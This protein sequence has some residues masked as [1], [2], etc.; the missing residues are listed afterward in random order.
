MAIFYRLTKSNMKG[1]SEG[2]YYA[3]AVSMGEMHTMDLAQV[4]SKNNSVTVGD[5]LASLAGLIEVMQQYLGDGQ[6]VVLDGLGR[7]RLSIESETVENP[8]DFRADKHV[9]GIRCNFI[10]E[11]K[12]LKPGDKQVKTFC[13]GVKVTEAPK[14]DVEK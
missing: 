7:F 11:G 9:K 5:V 4:I 12:V 3:K 2:R 14:N 13:S 8:G 6:T 1:K 10:P